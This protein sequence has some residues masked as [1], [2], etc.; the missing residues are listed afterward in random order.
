[1]ERTEILQRLTGIF[2]QVLGD[3]QIVLTETT[4][5]DDVEGWDSFN[6]INIIVGAEMEFGIKFSASELE[7]LRNVGDF[8]ALIERRLAAKK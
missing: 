4:T 2:V 1:M 3:D 5:A 7:A 8:L 6:H